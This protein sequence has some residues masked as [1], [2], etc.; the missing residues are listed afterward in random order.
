M[1]TSN[2]VPGDSIVDRIS[3]AISNNGELIA[4]LT[5]AFAEA[6]GRRLIVIKAILLVD[7]L[8]IGELTQM[9]AYQ[10]A[11]KTKTLMESYNT[12]ERCIW[13]LLFDNKMECIAPIPIPFNYVMDCDWMSI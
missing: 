11:M 9:S 3:E 12:Y 6:V 5:W 4:E 1:A 8:V 13:M 7:R 10:Y 2:F